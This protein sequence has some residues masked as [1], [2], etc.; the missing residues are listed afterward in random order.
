[1]TIAV[2]P[3]R[4]DLVQF[5]L[6]D[7]APRADLGRRAT[8]QWTTPTNKTVVRPSPSFLQASIVRSFDRGRGRHRFRPQMP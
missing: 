8:L 1:M 6:F 4:A 7:E 5:E 2:R 3:A